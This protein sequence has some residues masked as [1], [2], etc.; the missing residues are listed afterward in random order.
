LNGW[1]FVLLF[2]IPLAAVIGVG[3]TIN[4][5]Q[6]PTETAFLNMMPAY[7]GV[8]N[9]QTGEVYLKGKVVIIDKYID[10]L[11]DLYY[12]LPDELKAKTTAEVSTVVLLYCTGNVRVW[13][14]YGTQR[15]P[16]YDSSSC[17]ADIIDWTIPA[18]LDSYHTSELGASPSLVA[19]RV[20]EYLEGLPRK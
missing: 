16:I 19:D 14:V 10:R 20:L 12:D 1:H 11:N 17:D 15:K 13:Q 7:K 4:T 18:I 5:L 6:K 8:K 9:V 3:L 2:V